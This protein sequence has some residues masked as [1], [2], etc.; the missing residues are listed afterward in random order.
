VFH[1]AGKASFLRHALTKIC[2]RP[3]AFVTGIIL[4]AVFKLWLVHEEEIYGSANYYDQ[5]NYVRAAQ[6]WYWGAKYS[7]TSFAHGPAYPLWIALVHTSGLP[8]RI[9]Q[10]LL[11]LGGYAVFIAAVR[12]AG[13]PRFV[14]LLIYAAAILHPASY[15]LHNY[16]LT[17]NMYAAILPMALAGLIFVFVRSRLRDALWTG[18]MLGILWNIR[19]ESILICLLLAVFTALFWLWSFWGDRSGKVATSAIWKPMLVISGVLAFFVLGVDCANYCVFH[20]FSKSESSAPSVKAAYKALLRIRPNK[21]IRFI[22]VSKNTRARAYAVSPT[23]ARLQ[24]EL[25]GKTGQD[26][27]YQAWANLEIS[28]EI[29]A[30]WFLWALRDAASKIGVHKTGK[31]AASFYWKIADEI[32]RACDENRLPKRTVLFSLV[33]PRSLT[34]FK[35]FPHALQRISVIFVSRY[36]RSSQHEDVILSKSDR[37]LYDEMTSRRA[38]Y[39]RLGMLE[40]A[41][42]A[43]R[44]GDPVKLV[45]FCND[46]GDIDAATIQFSPRP[47]VVKHFSNDPS[48]PLNSQFVLSMT[49]FRLDEPSRRLIFITESGAQFSGSIAEILNGKSPV[50]TAAVADASAPLRCVIDSQKIIAPPKSRAIKLEELNGEYHAFFIQAL[51]YAGI[52]ATLILI[53]CFRTA[54]FGHPIYGV[55]LLLAVA[56]ILRTGLFI[57][58]DATAFPTNEPRYLFPV[59]PLF[60]CF[61][62][63]VIWQSAQ[64]VRETVI[65]KLQRRAKGDQLAT[66]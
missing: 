23:F 49:L 32:N 51:I 36:P 42:W 28:H 3:S 21:F 38:V 50:P 5:L 58:L 54:N 47:D 18:G 20:S 40:V 26:W 66:G 14:A 9:A 60:T 52:L 56:V 62:I 44:T 37:Q 64:V 34:S 15:Q 1:F 43:F 65:A 25:E 2:L 24:P 41:G 11:F 19:E 16:V 31:E 22:P 27:E 33:D 57:F 63:L 53:V 6:H 30:G 29:A 59:M 46:S 10:E 17:D 35:Y 55:L 13:V 45:G 39:A 61:L 8:L 48:V 4:L 12:A 7:W